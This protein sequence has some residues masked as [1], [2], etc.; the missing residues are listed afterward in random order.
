MD[1]KWVAILAFDYLDGKEVDIKAFDSKKAA[2]EWLITTLINYDILLL[3]SNQNKE[4]F[5]EEILSINM[6]LEKDLHQYIVQKGIIH[7]HDFYLNFEIDGDETERS[8][9]NCKIFNSSFMLNGK[10]IRLHF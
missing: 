3:K 8:G 10:E 1:N 7:Y 9:F 4:L 6:D 5:I 2:L